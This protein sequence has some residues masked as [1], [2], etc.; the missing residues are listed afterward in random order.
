MRDTILFFAATGVGHGT[1]P[2]LAPVALGHLF[3]L[4]FGIAHTISYTIMGF[5]IQFLYLLA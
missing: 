2:C 3:L 4:L 5:P 1:Q